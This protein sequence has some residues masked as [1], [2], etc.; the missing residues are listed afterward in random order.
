MVAKAPEIAFGAGGDDLQPLL[1]SVGRSPNVRDVGLKS[2]H[3]NS[4][5]VQLT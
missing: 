1:E 4:P 3:Q 5:A 2:S